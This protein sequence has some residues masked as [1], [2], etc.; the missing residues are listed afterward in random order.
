MVA[1]GT[2]E[3]FVFHVPLSFMIIPSSWCMRLLHSLKQLHLLLLREA[4]V[5][6]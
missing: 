3:I 6:P 2:E 5:L 4:E 1:D